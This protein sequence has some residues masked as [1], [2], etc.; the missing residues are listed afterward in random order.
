VQFLGTSQVTDV[1]CHI[2]CRFATNRGGYA[3]ERDRREGR[4]GMGGDGRGRQKD[5]AGAAR[6]PK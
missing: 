5:L 1:S 6:S 3:E 2:F 4:E